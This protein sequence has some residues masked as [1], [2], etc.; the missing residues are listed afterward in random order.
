MCSVY[1][2]KEV[3]TGR[4]K[5]WSSYSITL[6]SEPFTRLLGGGG[7]LLLSVFEVHTSLLLLN[8][9]V[10]SYGMQSLHLEDTSCLFLVQ[11]PLVSSTEVGK[12]TS[13]LPCLLGI[14]LLTAPL[15]RAAV[16]TIVSPGPCRKCLWSQPSYSCCHCFASLH[17][18]QTNWKCRWALEC[19]G[20]PKYTVFI[21]A[22]WTV[23]TE[24]AYYLPIIT[25]S[26]WQMPATKTRR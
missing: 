9:S 8:A 2:S 13:I 22:S 6:Q 16:L 11:L 19:L 18:V 26:D 4:C 15:Y 23:W 24:P 5:Y 21:S 12:H 10:F 25:L 7:R 20:F 1:I 17:S 14:Y 3:R